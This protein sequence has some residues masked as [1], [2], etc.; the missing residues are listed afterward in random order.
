MLFFFILAYFKVQQ[1]SQFDLL[2]PIQFSMYLGNKLLHRS[3]LLH[4]KS[5]ICIMLIWIFH[6]R[7]RHC[8]LSVTLAVLCCTAAKLLHPKSRIYHTAIRVFNARVRHCCLSF[9]FLRLDCRSINICKK[10]I[11]SSTFNWLIEQQ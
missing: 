8:C 10:N 3:R 6:A 7:V 9:A 2:S 11:H 1:F 4:P 5:R